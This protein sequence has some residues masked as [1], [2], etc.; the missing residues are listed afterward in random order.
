LIKRLENAPAEALILALTRS[1][2]RARREDRLPEFRGYEAALAGWKDGGDAPISSAALKGLNADAVLKR[3][4][5][6]AKRPVGEIYDAL[7]GA[8]ARNLLHFN[9]VYERATDNAIADNISWL[10]FTHALTF[11]NAA[12][13]LCEETPALW[14]RAL[15]QL[16]LFVGRNAKYVNEDDQSAW[17]VADR[18]AFFAREMD[19]LYDHGL[20]EP[21]VAC[22]RLKVVFALDD[23]LHSR[24]DAPWAETMCAGVNRYLNTAMKR[25]HGLRRAAQ[26]LDFIA[27]EG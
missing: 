22:H 12:R 14:P 23:E 19:A 3:V 7:L 20:P 26:A 27:K 25:H 21:I 8:A 1:L 4:L 5:Q 10:D 9:L 2:V 24:P 17:A 11:A 15:L 18:D 13:H 16:A 6:S